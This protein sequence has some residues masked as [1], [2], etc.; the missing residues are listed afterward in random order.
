MGSQCGNPDYIICEP[1]VQPDGFC[2]R[3][4]TS[5]LFTAANTTLICCPGTHTCNMIKTIPCDISLQQSG[6]EVVTTVFNKPLPPCGTDCCPFG[7]HCNSEQGCQLNED[8]NGLPPGA[9][10]PS[11]QISSSTKTSTQSSASS[12]TSQDNSEVTFTIAPEPKSSQPAEAPS[13]PTL[14]SGEIAAI[15]VGSAFGIAAVI[16]LLYLIRRTH[17]S[18]KARR[19]GR[20][21]QDA[22]QLG[23]IDSPS[24]NNS[25]V[26]EYQPVEAHSHAIYELGG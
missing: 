19:D 23:N 16:L 20:Q 8:F 6:A 13:G 25:K 2:C 26:A 5:C 14:S 11:S 22:S 9:V 17:R 21:A 7:Y 10:A 4:N 18:M 15:A 1:G 24:T 3:P 12:A